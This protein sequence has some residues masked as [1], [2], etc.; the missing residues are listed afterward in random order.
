M[1]SLV[2]R[3]TLRTFV[4]KGASG[5]SLLRP[6]AQLSSSVAETE[7]SA[8]TTEVQPVSKG[9]KTNAAEANSHRK[10]LESLGLSLDV[11][12]KLE[13]SIALIS[14]GGEPKD[15]K[16]SRQFHRIRG[17]SGNKGLIPRSRYVVRGRHSAKKAGH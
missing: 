13:G 6:A 10:L 14:V 9:R 3:Q 12:D 5:W 16:S 2:G 17:R 7:D 15:P 1:F 11:L 4:G 8:K